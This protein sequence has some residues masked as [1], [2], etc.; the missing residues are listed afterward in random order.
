MARCDNDKIKLYNYFLIPTSIY[1][2]QSTCNKPTKKYTLAILGEG[3]L[4]GS[5]VSL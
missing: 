3:V 5:G 4:V 1:T 2:F